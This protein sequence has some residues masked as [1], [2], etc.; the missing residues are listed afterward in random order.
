VGLGGEL[1]EEV[2][3]VGT[4]ADGVVDRQVSSADSSEREVGVAVYAEGIEIW[5]CCHRVF[6]AQKRQGSQGRCF[7]FI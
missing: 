2:V 5:L 4:E 3:F 6:V 1:F 7:G